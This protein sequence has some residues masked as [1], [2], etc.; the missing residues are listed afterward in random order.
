MDLEEIGKFVRVYI[1]SMEEI[2]QFMKDQAVLNGKDLLEYIGAA[3]D[4]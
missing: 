3:E 4:E 2:Y 1:K